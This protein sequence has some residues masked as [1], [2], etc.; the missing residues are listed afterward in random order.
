MFSKH[1]K[2]KFQEKW[3]DIPDANGH[4]IKLWCLPSKDPYVINCKLCP[5]AEINVSNNGFSSIKQH[6]K[7]ARHT[8]KANTLFGNN[9]KDTH[10]T[11]PVTDF[12]PTAPLPGGSK[13]NSNDLN[14]LRVPSPP[15]TLSDE[16]TIPSPPEKQT[17]VA[18]PEQVAKAE[19]LWAL[20]CGGS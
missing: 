6:S 4:L 16:L 19:C 12:F 20:K 2:T 8:A 15:A 5:H 18:I 11:K 14:E 10:G 13:Q 3:N 1:S 9:S 17:I 7:S